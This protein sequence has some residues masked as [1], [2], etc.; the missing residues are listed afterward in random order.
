MTTSTEP[1]PPP[2]PA[3]PALPADTRRGDRPV[4]PG[5]RAAGD[6]VEGPSGTPRPTRP[7]PRDSILPTVAAALQVKGTTLTCAATKRPGPPG[8]HP[9]VL[10]FLDA[11]PVHQRERHLGECPEA[12]LLSQAISAA[13]SGRRRRPGRRSFGESEARKA[14]RGARLTISRI[15]EEGDPQHGTFQPPC[16]SCAALLD[17]FGVAVVPPP[18]TDGEARGG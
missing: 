14:L 11:L 4:L 15:R 6:R 12:V 8:L 18:N 7:V 10:R 16:R 5:A 2:P 17:H 9:L 1:A 3:G 13:E